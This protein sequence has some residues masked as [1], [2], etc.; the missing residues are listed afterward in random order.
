MPK[1]EA[2]IAKVN[3]ESQVQITML[4]DRNP[5]DGAPTIEP[6][7]RPQSRIA[8]IA[9]LNPAS[10]ANPLLM[11]LFKHYGH[12]A[13]RDGQAD[14]INNIL[15]KQRDVALFWHT[16]YGK[17]ITFVLPALHANKRALV[18]SPHVALSI[19]QCMKVSHAVPLSRSK[20]HELEC[21]QQCHDHA[22]QHL[23]PAHYCDATS[24]HYLVC[25]VN[26]M[27]P[28]AA[29]CL[30]ANS[31]KPSVR[32]KLAMNATIIYASPEMLVG[33]GQFAQHL[34]TLHAAK[35]FC[36]WAVDE[37]DGICTNSNHRPA[38]K[39]VRTIRDHLPHVPCLALTGSALPTSRQS[40]VELLHLQ[41]PYISIRA[42]WTTQ[43]L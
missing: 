16:G 23:V 43:D 5:T 42:S 32:L 21:T 26:E 19:D 4:N 39:K 27:A 30:S 18:V 41:D 8:P 37:A 3:Q 9:E 31:C 28:G 2:I 24:S 20:L 7:R 34:T 40:I 17:S 35:P 14:V 11:S 33:P 29:V 38:W 15:D 13:F 25:E 6:T 12:V 10:L 1:V 36:V 22:Q